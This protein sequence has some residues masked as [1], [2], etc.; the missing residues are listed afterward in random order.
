MSFKLNF[1]LLR[2]VEYLEQS[3]K[4][5]HYFYLPRVYK[6][7]PVPVT[8]SAHTSS[9]KFLKSLPTE[10]NMYNIISAS[11][12]K[13]IQ[14]H[15]VRAPDECYILLCR[16][17]GSALD[18]GSGARTSGGNLELRPYFFVLK[19]VSWRGSDVDSGCLLGDL[20]LVGDPGEDPEHAGGITS[21]SWPG[22]P[23]DPP[24]RVRKCCGWEGKLGSAGSAC[25]QRNQTPDKWKTTDGWM[26]GRHTGLMHALYA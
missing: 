22:N 9:A 1:S 7:T 12:R 5:Q 24:E 10:N 8:E 4:S 11:K 23:S 20:P 17:L 18:R 21:P 19:G 25:C 3:R 16:A 14:G 13:E 26:D 6:C 2:L 15:H